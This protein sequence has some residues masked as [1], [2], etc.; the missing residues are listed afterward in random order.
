MQN[1]KI[2]DDETMVTCRLCGERMKRLYGK[3]MDRHNIDTKKYKEM[4]PGAPLMSSSDLKSSTKSS[5]LHMKQD[6]YKKMF[7]EM[8]SGDRNP[9]HI[10]NSTEEERKSR[11]PFSKKFIKYEKMNN[12]EEV[13]SK[14][15]KN[16]VKDRL[17]T[18]QK[19]YWIEKG[20]S[21]EDAINKVSDR[22]KT[23][24]LEKCIEKHGEEK[25]IEVYTNRQNKWQKSLLENGNIKCGY[26]GVS[27][28]LFYEIINNYKNKLELSN[29]YFA[30]KNKEYFLSIKGGFFIYDFVDLNNKK[31]IEYNGD[32]YHA[33]PLIYKENDK[34]HPYLKENG[35][36]AKFI[37]EKDSEKA[38]VANE[39]GFEILVIWDS[40]YKKNKKETI[41]R[42]L[43][44]L[45]K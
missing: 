1:F 30:T 31:I 32:Q 17:T 22:Q 8:F 15:A 39:N 42:C 11:S 20:Y 27:Q 28:E 24:S 19:E 9:N 34:P 43:K 25:G 2:I 6:K 5:G 12:V 13:I 33:N 14:F 21:E 44:F 38:R 41:D 36:I 26:S 35:P 3:H 23:F 45:G 18:N 16:A 7:S 37:W 40:E 10:S 29:V 4:F